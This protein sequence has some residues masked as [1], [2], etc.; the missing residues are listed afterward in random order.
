MLEHLF[1]FAADEP[2]RYP[3]SE[4]T[5]REGVFQFIF[6]E[7]RRWAVRFKR[8][9]MFPIGEWTGHL[10]ITEIAALFVVL[11]FRN[12]ALAKGPP[13]K[14]EHDARPAL[15]SARFLDHFDVFARCRE[16]FERIRQGMPGIHFG[17]GSLNS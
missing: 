9:R 10:D 1:K 6:E 2:A 12:P 4:K 16:T 8:M 7:A 14:P 13:P 17:C 3:S 5:E 15:D 11:M